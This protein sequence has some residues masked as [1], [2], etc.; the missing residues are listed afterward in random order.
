MRCAQ[1]PGDG[2]KIE[3]HGNDPCKTGNSCGGSPTPMV[4]MMCRRLKVVW[5]YGNGKFLLV[6]D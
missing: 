1:V 4:A 2:R 5:C 3:E 6:G